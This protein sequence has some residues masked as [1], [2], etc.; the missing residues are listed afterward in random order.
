MSLVLRRITL[1]IPTLLVLSMTVFVLMGLAPGDATDALL[2]DAN[3][4]AARTAICAEVGCD[5]PLLTRYTH[6][7]GGV[8]QGDLGTSAKTGR[9]VTDEIAIR[10][11]YTLTVAGYALTL[12]LILGV[13][14]GTLAAVLH[15]SV[16]D[17][18]ITT[19]LALTAATPTFWIA[20]MLVTIFSVWL[21]WLPVFG[22]GSAAHYILPV[23]SV[24]IALLP[25]VAR[26]TRSSLLETTSQRFVIV[27]AAKGLSS[28]AIYWRH[29]R[30]AAAIPILTYVGLQAVHLVAGLITIEIVFN[31]PG[32]GGLAVQAALD[33]DIML[34]QGVVLVIAALTFT[35]LLIV[36]CAVMLLDPR[37]GYRLD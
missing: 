19:L 18:A 35:V 28:N 37:I 30:P 13:S 9:S 32:L 14:L 6:Y 36:D 31:L 27:A 22:V 7:L 16:I 23:I 24:A 26:I 10:L 34:I 29:I 33:R 5:V 15:N 21:H 20:L 3:T 12:G 4:D 25:G 11:P 2:D 8:L 1:A 17:I